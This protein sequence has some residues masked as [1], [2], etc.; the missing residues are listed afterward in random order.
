MPRALKKAMTTDTEKTLLVKRL[1]GTTGWATRRSQ[2]KK[3]TSTTAAIASRPTTSGSV[4][5][6]VLVSEKAIS[7]GTRPAA[8]AT[9]PTQSMSRSWARERTNGRASETSSTAATPTG[10]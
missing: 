1:N 8:S 10:T 3:P 6:W 9:Q 7:M 2:K 4:H 5:L